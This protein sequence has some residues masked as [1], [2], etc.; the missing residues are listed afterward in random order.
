MPYPEPKSVA[1]ASESA[2]E[3]SEYDAREIFR[4]LDLF[5]KAL[6]DPSE[7]S[8]LER[9]NSREELALRA[10][11][12]LK[13]RRLRTRYFKQ[14]MFGE[15]AWDMLLH[16]YSTEAVERRQTVGRIAEV[17]NAPLSTAIR[18]IDFL[19]RE[20]LVERESHPTDRRA[21]FIRLLPKARELL[22]S[23]L[24]EAP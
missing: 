11:S 1:P 24:R 13:A 3:L 15:A 17:V 2:V 19:E 23:Y 21:N 22:D 16:L 9:N 5:A 6:V 14:A 12:V 18:W 20:G 10:Q 7:T 8:A 4:L